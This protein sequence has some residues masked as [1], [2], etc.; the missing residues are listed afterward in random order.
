MV[1]GFYSMQAVMA[2]NESVSIGVASTLLASISF[3]MLIMYLVNHRD[4]DIRRYTYQVLSSTTSIFCAVLLFSSLNDVV[5]A[6]FV[7]G[8]PRIPSIA[9]GWILSLLF[10][11]ALQ[12]VLAHF[13]GIIRDIP[14]DGVME[15]QFKR[16]KLD[17]KCFSV[18][19]AHMTG[20]ANINLWAGIQQ[21]QTFRS[22]FMIWIP[23]PLAYLAM[24]VITF[25]DGRIRRFLM[26]AN[27][28]QDKDEFEKSWDKNAEESENDVIGLT[29][30]FISVQAVRFWIG[31]DLPDKEGHEEDPSSHSYFQIAVLFM[32]GLGILCSAAVLFYFRMLIIEKVHRTEPHPENREI[33]HTRSHEYQEDS[34]EQQTTSY[35]GW[36]WNHMV[37]FIAEFVE[38]EEMP[39][40][41]D[42]DSDVEEEEE[43]VFRRTLDT[44]IVGCSMGNAWAI[45]FASQQLCSTLYLGSDE[46][47]PSVVLALSL[48]TLCFALIFVL[49]SV[50]DRA[51]VEGDERRVK[52]IKLI[53]KCMGL[54][55][56]FAWEQCFDAAVGVLSSAS[57]LPHLTKLALAVFCALLLIPAWRWYILPMSHGSGWFFGFVVS[58]EW[59]KERIETTVAHLH[60]EMRRRSQETC[61]RFRRAKGRKAPWDHI[62]SRACCVAGHNQNGQAPRSLSRGLLLDANHHSEGEGGLW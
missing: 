43:G 30:S 18:L 2:E 19:V 37:S 34:H 11:V 16:W 21:M 13:S 12:F 41:D 40:E 32:A 48:S 8:G 45:F 33:P 35:L 39:D 55:I 7:N 46:T 44:C 47:I 56:G 14:Q 9:A 31:G 20:F 57:P 23:V 61:K 5:E 22:T 10:F 42:D 50:A 29:L 15:L 1:Y 17:T 59:D 28:V 60:H 27:T 38:D 58:E 49:D 52:I 54:S 3:M 26:G 53:I 51:S 6:Y 62:S 24:Q 25:A 4:D 36:A